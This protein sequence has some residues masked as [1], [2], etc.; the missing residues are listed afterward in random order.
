V[1]RL[2]ERRATTHRDETFL[3]LRQG[4][5]TFGEV[6]ETA[7]RLACGLAARGVTQASH[8]AVMLPNSADF[9]HAIFALARLGAVAVP[10]NTEYKGDLLRHVITTS[11]ADLV[12]VDEP[13]VERL[14]VV[15]ADLRDLRA[16]VVRGGGD[17]PPL[18]TATLAW[19]D[20]LGDADE[21]PRP[22]VRFS[23]LQAIMYTSGTTGPSK[24]VLVPHA[25]AL[26]CALDSM[27]YMAYGPD[28]TVYCP[29][30]LYHAGGL[31]DGM[32][33]ALLAGT[34]IA[35]VERFSASRFWDD[36]RSFGATHAMG[37]FDMIPIL[38]N[39]PP[40]DQ[41]RDHPLRRFYMGKSALDESLFE[42]FGVRAVETYTSTEA[43]IGTGSPFGEW[44]TG[45][46]GRPN[47][48]RYE[49]AIVDEQDRKLP[50]G[51]P[52]EIVLRPKQPYVLTTGY[53]NFPEVTAETFRN[54]WFHTGDRCYRDEDGY[55][56]FVDRIKDSLRRGGENISAFEVEQAVNA[57][58]AVLESAAFGVPSEL[59]EEELK[60]AVVL[61]PGAELDPEELVAH[62]HDRLP[63]F[64]VPRYVETVGEL[65]RTGTGKIAKHVLRG[66]GDGGITERTWDGGR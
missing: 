5:L 37:V 36:I 46:C 53:Y 28:E 39:R 45:S 55:Y 24:G 51:E 65:P 38:L 26:T 30:P 42:R 25:L 23:D 19:N 15:E 1:G 7:R 27:R 10:I 33:L 21:A 32:I 11:D 3:K 12:I 31:W 8:V 16:V 20:L 17:L 58:H 13:Y 35:V 56:Y 29:L 2:L 41:D 22:P 43:G 34:P 63:G 52:G 64:M 44:R 54:C 59:E 14:A 62:C 6:E 4:E 66:E 9:L 48:E 49:V 50:P 18:R 40:T 57:H 47:A 61:Q 60:V